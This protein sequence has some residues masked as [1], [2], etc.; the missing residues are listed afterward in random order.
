MA[1]IDKKV[2]VAVWKR[3]VVTVYIPAFLVPIEVALPVML[4]NK[5]LHILDSFHII[6]SGHKMC[7]CLHQDP[8][9]ACQYIPGIGSQHAWF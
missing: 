3:K 8:Y 5:V 2:A 7:Y 9:R 6:V 1:M 4:T